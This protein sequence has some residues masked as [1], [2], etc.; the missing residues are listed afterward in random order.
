MSLF[1]SASIHCD[2]PGELHDFIRYDQCPEV[3]TS[4]PDGVDRVVW[5]A[6]VAG[7]RL[8]GD[9]EWLCPRHAADTPITR[10]L[11]G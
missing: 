10:G 11:D 3:Y 6:L 2:A 1:L 9:D 7:W 8:R 4:G 5:L